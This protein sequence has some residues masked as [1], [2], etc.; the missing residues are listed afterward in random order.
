MYCVKRGNKYRF[1]ERY[2]I[3]G[4]VK[5]VSVTMDRDTPQSRKKAAELLAAKKPGSTSGA[6]FKDLREAYIKD[7]K[8]STKMTTWG[9]DEGTM[10]RIGTKLDKIKLNRLTS[11]QIRQALLSLS[12][13]PTTLNEYLKRLKTCFRWGYQ[14]DYLDST[15]CIDKIARWDAPSKR[16]K[17]RGKYLE[18]DEL[19]AVIAAASEYH[20]AVIEFLA[21]SGLR[22]GELIALD[23][24]DVTDVISV[25]KNYDYIHDV[26]TTPKTED[27]IRDVNVQPEL[28]KCIAKINKISNTHRMVS[29]KHVP[30][31]VVNPYG[32]RLSYPAF[33]HR[34]A[35]LTEKVTGKRLTPHALRHTH[36]SLLAEQGVPIDTISRRLGHHDS[37]ITREIYLHVTKNIARNDAEI[38]SRVALL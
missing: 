12:T 26:M 16:D 29:G 10:K 23:K 33:A 6:T 4:V 22:I 8:V 13:N 2:N 5:K 32:G 11:G 20:A 25:T 9:R 1:F 38:L 3:N 21:L 24:T 27:S 37:K 17:V 36:T 19:K 28:A 7:K 18:R 31:F 15:A 14:N 35:D 34:F 30:Y